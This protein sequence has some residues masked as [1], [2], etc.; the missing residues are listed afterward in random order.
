M[1][2]QKFVIWLVAITLV[3]VLLALKAA[4]FQDYI[5]WTII[6]VAVRL[7]ELF[8]RTPLGQKFQK[9]FEKVIDP[10]LKV[11]F[12]TLWWIQDNWLISLIIALL[13]FTVVAITYS[14]IR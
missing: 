4:T 13:L 2:K 3:V 12:E 6:A 1:R 5:H 14:I 10:I 11:I 7:M 9:I 8:D